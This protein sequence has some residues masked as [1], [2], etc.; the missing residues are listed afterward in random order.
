M[1]GRMG[2][3]MNGRMEG[4]TGRRTGR[5]M[6]GRTDIEYTYNKIRL[7]RNF[8]VRITRGSYVQSHLRERSRSQPK[9]DDT[10]NIS[11]SPVLQLTYSPNSR[12]VFYMSSVE[13]VYVPSWVLFRG[14]GAPLPAGKGFLCGRI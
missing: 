5:R 2:G 9:A 4:R 8:R 1:D 7:K 14:V 11:Q 6:V 12:Y 10:M 13:L 3:W